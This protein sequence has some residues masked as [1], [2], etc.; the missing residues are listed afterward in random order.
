MALI[1]TDAAAEQLGV[2]VVE[3]EIADPQ[4]LRLFARSGGGCACSGPAF[5]MTIDSPAE[6][7]EVITVNGIRFLVDPLSAGNLDGASIDYIDDVMRKGFTIEAP[8]SAAAEGAACG[9]GGGGHH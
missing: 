2:L 3:H 7:D 6:D 4:G 9:C 5:G 1:V 8:N